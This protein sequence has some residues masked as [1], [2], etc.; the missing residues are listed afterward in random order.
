MSGL[1]R[2][3]F[4]RN[5]IIAGVASSTVAGPGARAFSLR[6][7]TQPPVAA[8]TEH[9]R[10][11]PEWYRRKIKQVQ[12]QMERRKLDAMVLLNATNVIYTTGYF[13][14]PTERPLAALIPKSGEPTLFVPG[15]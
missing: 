8:K 6:L 2:R 13:H 12:Q 5:G 14:R 4:V 15:L 1:S 10:L 7:Q 11:Q 9:D 3:V